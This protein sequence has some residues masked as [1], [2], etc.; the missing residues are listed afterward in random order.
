MEEAGRCDD[1][2]LMRDGELLAAETPDA[3]RERT[4][5]QGLDDAFLALIEGRGA[6]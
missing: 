4:G 3:L 5:K 2:L 1:L 6:R